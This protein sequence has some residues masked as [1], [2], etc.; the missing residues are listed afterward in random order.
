MFNPNP[1]IQTLTVGGRPLC[2]VID[3]ALLEPER[4]V[5]YAAASQDDFVDAPHNAYPGPELRLPED[6]SAHLEQFFSTHLRQHFAARRMLRMYSRLSLTTRA[7]DE[8][9][10]AQRLCHVDRLEMEAG[11]GIAACV[12]Y[13]FRDERL[14]GTGFYRPLRPMAEIAGLVQD[15]MRLPSPEFAAKREIAPGYMTQS[16]A[17]FEKLMSVP[18]R[19]NR[20]IFYSGTIFHSGDITAPDLLSRD[21]RNGRLTLNGFFLYRRNL[22]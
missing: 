16:N 10:P 18:A 20:L 12:L 14:G 2:H 3:D 17:Y 13:L 8:L 4:W 5:E 22:A 21:P 1:R 19:W 6:I 15:A 7:P 9:A 11:Q